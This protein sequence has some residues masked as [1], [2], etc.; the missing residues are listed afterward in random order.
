MEQ[1]LRVL[2]VDEDPRDRALVSRELQQEFGPLRVQQ[3]TTRQ[4][5]SRALETDRFDLVITGQRLGWAEGI[6]ILRDVKARHP[7][8]PVLM[9]A[10]AAEERGAAEALEAGLDDYVL[11]SPRQSSRLSAAVR[12]ALARARHQQAMREAEDLYRSLAQ[13]SHDAIYSVSRDGTFSSL[14]PAFHRITGWE[15][16]D[17]IGRPLTDLIHDDDRRR[18]EEM[19][20]RALSGENPP[21]YELRIVTASGEHRIGE[22]SITPRV[23]GE[24]VVGLVGI[25]RDITRRRRLEDQL[26]QSQKLEAI[27][28]LAGGVAHDFNNLLTAI[29]GY[30][31]L[32]SCELEPEDPRRGRVLEIQRAA[33]RAAALTRQLL[34]FARRQVMQPQLVDLN[35]VVLDLERLLKRLIGEPIELRTALD[36]ALGRVK[37]DPG[38]IGQVLLNLVVNARDAMTHGGKLTIHTGSVELDDRYA[39]GH[40]GAP[41]GHY[42][43]LSVTDTGDGIDAQTLAHIFE[44]FFTT[45][46]EG[47]GLGLATVYG[48]V[49][50]S[51]GEI[52]V[53]SEPG[54]GTQFK[55]LL[56]RVDQ[57]ATR[58]APAA[59]AERAPSRG[60]TVLVVEDDPLVRGLAAEVLAEN[61]F[62]VLKAKDPEEALGLAR[63]AS[64]RTIDLLVTDV[65]L[66]GMPGPDL[67]RTLVEERPDLKVLFTSG[68]GE[69]AITHQGVIEPDA[70][71]V[72]KPFTPE[73]LL[74][75]V[76]DA[77]DS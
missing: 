24:R 77:L 5:F 15:P 62:D 10:V 44:P 68:Y 21:T 51:G 22:F 63:A 36:P 17:W 69:A 8:C 3:I 40:L 37:A 53:Y 45:K 71:F 46:P 1:G 19:F 58:P 74:D 64:D 32:L 30:A 6:A 9:L 52:Y 34:A 60:A 27:G 11:T 41:K 48:I 25:V 13:A 55:I 20:R 73:A 72:E 18:A 33:D 43:A 31:E 14:N 2:L 7:D 66:P 59:R 39:L 47:T 61:G 70:R 28:E 38:Q 42:V 65:I 26:R 57:P 67:A 12:S 56:P 29:L 4:D 35:E 49:K 16:A 54:R 75:C 76:R 23:E 50:Q